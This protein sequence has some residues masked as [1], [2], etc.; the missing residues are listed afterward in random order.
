MLL[1]MLPHRLVDVA[2]DDDQIQ[3]AVEVRVEKRAAEAQ[4]VARRL[5]D[6][7]TPARRRVNAACAAAGRGPSS[8]YRSS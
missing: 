4:A 5:S 8:R 1:R 7:A 2:V 6:A 3:P